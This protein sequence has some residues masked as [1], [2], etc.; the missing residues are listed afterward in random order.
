MQQGGGLVD[1]YCAVFSNT[2][3][4]TSA[5]ALNDSSHFNGTHTFEI[6]NEGPKTVHYLLSHASALTSYTFESNASFG[7]PNK[8]PRQDMNVSSVKI[9]S[10]RFCLHPGKSKSLTVTIEPPHV[11]SSLLAVY[12][13]YIKL[14]W[15]LPNLSPDLFSVLLMQG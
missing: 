2:T 8:S 11:N 12:S 14:V 15:L 6:K 9:S 1:A 5:L 4:S 10:E 3:V 7:R 13:G